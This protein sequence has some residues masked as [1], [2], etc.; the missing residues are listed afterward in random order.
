MQRGIQELEDRCRRAEAAL[1]TL[2]ERDRLL[3]ESA[4]FGIFVVDPEGHVFGANQKMQELLAW[5]ADRD[6]AQ[7][8]IFNHPP[9]LDS[10]VADAFRRC[11][12]KKTRVTSDHPCVP[13]TVGCGYLRYHISPVIEK[14]GRFSGIIGFVEDVTELKQAEE[15]MIASEKK[16][17]LLFESAPVAMIERDASELKQHLEQLRA[18]GVSDLPGY[19]DQHPQELIRCLGLIKTVDCNSAFLDLIK[20]QT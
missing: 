8:N 9:L 16:Y 5:P 6:I 19:F 11:Q 14:D 2:E 3:G 13:G 10:G 17:R 12:E 1:R 18:D 20:T 15:T 4:P 7:L